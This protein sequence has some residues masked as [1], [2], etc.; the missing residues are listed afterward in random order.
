VRCT[1]ATEEPPRGNQSIYYAWLTLWHTFFLLPYAREKFLWSRRFFLVEG[2]SA[3]L[4][5]GRPK[6]CTLKCC[7]WH[8]FFH[9][10]WQQRKSPSLPLGQMWET[11]L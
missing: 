5:K 4:S 7:Q 11:L 6:S 2:R 10:I 9:V 8:M 3:S 1:L